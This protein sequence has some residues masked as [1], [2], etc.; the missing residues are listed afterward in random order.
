MKELYPIE[1]IAGDKRIGFNDQLGKARYRDTTTNN[2]VKEVIEWLKEH[3]CK[4]NS[5]AII[6][7][8]KYV[9]VEEQSINLI[10]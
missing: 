4:P 10:T 3:G 5:F 2:P 6:N 7:N 8:K 1:V 9:L